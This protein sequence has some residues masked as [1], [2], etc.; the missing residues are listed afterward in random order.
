VPLRPLGVGD[1]LSGVFATLRNHAAALY[2][3]L[4]WVVLG[5][6]ALMAACGV[7]AAATLGGVL[8]AV[9][10]DR[11]LTGAEVGS[12]AAVLGG[13]ALLLLLCFLMMFTVS[14]ATATV[15]VRHAVVGR[16]P[17]TRQVWSEA[18]PMLWRVLGSQLLIGVAGFGL[19]LGS[20]LLFALFAAVAHNVLVP[21]VGLLLMVPGWGA[22]MYVQVRLVLDVPVLVMEE[23]PVV[24]AARRAWRLNEGAWWRSLGI[25]YLVNLIGSTVGQFVITPFVFGGMFVLLAGLS[26]D[27]A[28]T[29]GSGPTLDPAAL[30]VTVVLVA[31]GL[32]AGTALTMPLTPL[33]NALLYIDRRIRRESLD[34]AL[35]AAAGVAPWPQPAAPPAAPGA[36]PKAPPASAGQDAPADARQ[37]AP[38]NG[39]QGPPEE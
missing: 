23:A 31:I 3:P 32:I 29:D 36:A 8:D 18:R 6:V 21:V 13:S 20:L 7:V 17:T 24:A 25:P 38:E 4:L 16:R 11:A 30:V 15:V 19:M 10:T 9:R 22:A 37:D 39:T 1:I 34:V 28:S 27:Q 33:T 5:G 12:L 26:Q 14:A 2:L 35:A